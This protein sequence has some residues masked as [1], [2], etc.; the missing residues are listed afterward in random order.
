MKANALYRL[1]TDDWSK[2][3]TQFATHHR[4]TFE[5]VLEN[6]GTIAEARDI[7][8]EAFLYYIQLIELK[9]NKLFERAEPIV[10]S[11]S[12]KL[13][14]RKLEKRR[15]DLDYVKHRREFF[16]MDDAFQEIDSINVRS[17]KTADK[18][19]VIGEPCRTLVLEHVGRGIDLSEVGGRLGFSD[20]DRAF[21]QISR[22]MHKLVKLTEGKEFEV[23]EARF[24]VL[25]RYALDGMSEHATVSSDD[26]KVCLA[27]LSRAVAMVRNHVNRSERTSHFDA[28][29]SKKMPQNIPLESSST[30]AQHGGIKQKLMKAAA[31]WTIATVVAVGVSALTAFNVAEAVHKKHSDEV[32]EIEAISVDTI[33]QVIEVP[34]A[35][36]PENLSAFIVS[37]GGY[38]ITA[39]APLKGATRIALYSEA[40]NET[41]EAHLLKV[42]TVLNLA[43]IKTDH[44]AFASGRVP[45][46]FAP[47]TV[48]LGEAVFSVGYTD[49]VFSFSEG[50]VAN[51]K[52]ASVAG[53]R[54]FSP[55]IGAP[56]IGDKGQIAG[57]VI[58]TSNQLGSISEMRTS[59][60]IAK[61]VKEI[62]DEKGLD[63][64]L[65]ARNGLFYNDKL[66]Q[67]EKVK[68]F[69]FQLKLS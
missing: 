4:S 2:L 20:E 55:S 23:D 27:V 54:I 39:A 57:M 51:H 14:L 8:V 68:P 65:T 33:E 25:L 7:Y 13:W 37:T 26:E 1:D 6:K 19:A 17:A 63:L 53:T 24:T 59:T 38:A 49:D 16:E 48:N 69:V 9:G 29:Q 50:N 32:A 62:S 67:V 40:A 22:C 5:F 46:R 35:I 41:Y 34:E 52:S 11:F 47:A 31:I 18:L 66:E 61:W 42:D 21:G 44:E 43:L 58:H 10:Y 45:Y 15:V 12:R 36:F 3:E 56:V 64:T 28:I 30:E 60:A